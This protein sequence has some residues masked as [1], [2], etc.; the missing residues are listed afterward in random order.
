MAKDLKLFLLSLGIKTKELKLYQTAFTHKS[1][2]HLP[3]NN[4]ERLELL[5]D[6]ILRLCLT[7]ILFKKYPD[8]N[9]G[10]L[11]KLLSIYLQEDLLA[12]ISSALRLEDYLICGEN[13]IQNNISTN[14]SLRSDLVE[15]LVAALYLDYDLKKVKNFVSKIFKEY[16]EDIHIL[17]KYQDSKSKLQEITQ[18]NNNST[19]EY[20]LL[21][22]NGPDHN[23]IFT[24]TCKATYNS[25]NFIAEGYGKSKK[26]AEQEAA[27]KIIDSLNL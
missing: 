10:E 27:K 14:S 20:L 6:S 1:Y 11:S 2:N 17:N 15:A 22:T 18:S 19:P 3:A 21:N 7:E 24:I 25:T 23:K 16:L 8:Y 26:Q 9:E 12:D 4:Y 5:G 13:E